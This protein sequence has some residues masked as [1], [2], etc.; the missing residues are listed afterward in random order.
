MRALRLVHRTVITCHANADYDALAS[1]I[2][3]ELLYPGSALIFP[4]TMEASLTQFFNEAASELYSF[5]TLKD[6]DLD[7]VER[8]IVADTQQLSR[9]L[10]VQPLLDKG[11]EVHVWD[12]HPPMQADITADYSVVR[13]VGSTCTLVCEALEARGITPTCQDA[14][15]LGLGLYSDTGSFSYNSTCPDD[16]R[17][18]A[19]L[20]EHDMDLPFIVERMRH[21]MTG[22]HVKILNIL[23]EGMVKREAGPYS[24]FLADYM[25]DGFVPDFAYIV[26]QVME[27]EPSDVLFG[28]AAMEGKVQ[29]VA[30][31]RVEA[32]DVGRICRQL[33]GGG[34]AYAA[35][36]SVHGKSL[37]EVRDA[38]F[39]S[40]FL[41]VSPHRLA[42]DLMS[43]PA[44]GLEEGQTLREAE[45]AMTRYGLKAAP[46]FRTGTQVCMGLLEG[47]IAARAIAHGLGDMPLRD[48]IQRKA[49]SVSP[50]TS[51]QRLMDIIVGARQ[52]L[53]PVVEEGNTIGV[54][55][56]T[57]LI[58]MFVS[59]PDQI[60]VR[61]NPTPREHPLG[62]LLQSRIPRAVFE[63]M[64]E[65]GRL[66]ES[67]GVQVFVVGG[68]VRNILL[69]RP[70]DVHDVDLVVEGD[71]IAFAKKLA[72]AFG[73]RVRVHQA[74]LTAL[75]M[76]HDAEGKEQRYDVATARLEYYPSPAALPTVELSSI[77]M[78]LYRRDF[79]I[80]A[81]AIRLNPKNFG[82]LV[83][84]FGGQSD[85][86]RK[87]IKVIHTLSFVE[88]PT[89][90]IRAVRFVQRYGF[91]M[92]V[93]CEK[94][95]RNALSLDLVSK[96]SGARIAHELYLIFEEADPPACLVQ[97]HTLKVLKAIHPDLALN[98]EREAV[99]VALH[100]VLDWYRLLYL[101]EKADVT[102]LYLMALCSGL[103][104][105]KA[106][107]VLL[108]LDASEQ[109]QHSI[110]TLREQVVQLKDTVRLWHK[111]SG[112]VSE[113]YTMLAPVPLEGVLYLMARVTDKKNNSTLSRYVYQWRQVR[114]DISGK[115]LKAMGLPEGPR[116]G[117]ILRSVLA[118]KL[119][120]VAKSR[121][122]QLLLARS[123]E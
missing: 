39:K 9:L 42:R 112:K 78:D 68:L 35:S 41:Q 38:V 118:A 58:N 15:I 17:A 97:L 24:V 29:V 1:M 102:L 61:A 37:L 53:V 63:R 94:L 31:S 7:A 13:P 45:A 114:L 28:F 60:P 72:K 33:G 88:D 65:V 115:D 96:L 76:F 64:Q 23:L 82:H 110:K 5:S 62:K 30:R 4:G 47:H 91:H 107:D 34:H 123:L 12:H 119:D 89:R 2:G 27:I 92:S 26:Q 21:T 99:L 16:Y 70:T 83:D 104:D 32:V 69:S 109:T 90:I 98:K 79:T 8:L 106:M 108:R 54:V 52:R 25:G 87:S 48:Y 74:F 111:N 6:L 100:K 95:V 19:W 55:T 122:E 51:L 11:V 56:R 77:K 20:C 105:E 101:D 36:A 67:L 57:D 85:I 59:E 44:S 10:H 80:N 40:I 113:L 49:F 22:E 3:L 46:I 66:A 50:D 81:M 93:Q 18:A 84:F 14:T 75:V 120:G 73:G 86:Q 116:Y 43:A 121:E 71:G 103:D 117:E